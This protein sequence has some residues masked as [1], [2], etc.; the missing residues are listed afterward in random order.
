MDP[1][2]I[3][4]IIFGTGAVLFG[5]L[6]RVSLEH[7]AEGG[8]F[9]YLICVGG[10]L[11]FGFAFSITL[12]VAAWVWFGWLWAVAAFFALCGAWWLLNRYAQ[13]LQ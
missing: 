2:G 13:R 4:L 9:T 3:L 1:L 6:A 7:A 8:C 10:L 11:A 12:M 5:F